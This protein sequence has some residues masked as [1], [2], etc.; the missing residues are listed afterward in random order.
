MTRRNP[1][2]SR[3]AAKGET[4][5]TGLNNS[6]GAYKQFVS[7][8]YA[9]GLV[10]MKGHQEPYT[11]RAAQRLRRSGLSLISYAKCDID[12]DADQQRLIADLWASVR[13]L[14]DCQQLEQATP[15]FKDAC[16]Q[17][18]REAKALIQSL[19]GGWA[20]RMYPMLDQDV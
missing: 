9:S 18:E 3:K 8:I 13:Y 12:M 11:D 6:Y 20:E 14:Q 5:Y 1:T 2:T 7:L 19:N 10:I 4:T 15:G 16:G 17:A